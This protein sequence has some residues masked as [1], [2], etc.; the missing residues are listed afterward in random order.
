V[1]RGTERRASDI[2]LLIVG[3]VSFDDAVQA[4]YPSQEQ[5]RREINPIVYGAAEFAKKGKGA[6]PSRIMKGQ[7]LFILGT[8]NELKKLSVHRKTPST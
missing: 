8:E 4:M 5:L 2:D 1:A 3:S 7:K 6:F